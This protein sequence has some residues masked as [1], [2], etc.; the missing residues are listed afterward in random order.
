V[1]FADVIKIGR[2]HLQDAT[3]ITLG[4][5]ISGWASQLEL[6]MRALQSAMPFL[7]ELAQ[8][9]TAVGTGINAPIGFD[10]QV[11]QEIAALCAAPF[12]SAPNKFAALAG[13]E[14]MVVTSGALKTL[15]VAALK[16]ANDVRWLS[17]GPRAGIGELR[18]PENEPGSSIMPGKV[19]PTQA[20]ALSMVAMQVMGNDAAVS[21]AAASGNFELNVAKPVILVNVLRS[22]RLLSDALWSFHERC[23]LGIEPRRD[24]IAMHLAQSLMLVTALSPLIGYDRAAEVAKHAHTHGLTL[25]EAALALDA[26]DATTFDLVVRPENMVGGG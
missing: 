26:V 2:T 21:I 3:P 11:A 1:A 8:G 10:V 12:T 5:E 16:V 23:A 13:H 20:E 24:R 7:N 22:I 17:S 4:Q 14:A 18:I 25:R 9:G 6:A 19:N 15:A